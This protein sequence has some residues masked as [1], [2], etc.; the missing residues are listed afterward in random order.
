MVRL[1]AALNIWIYIVTAR[2]SL[3]PQLDRGSDIHAA[4][5]C[6]RSCSRR[7][8]PTHAERLASNGACLVVLSCRKS[9]RENPPLAETVSFE[10]NIRF[11]HSQVRVEERLLLMSVCTNCG[12]AKIVSTYDRTLRKWEESHR[13]RPA[14]NDPSPR[15]T[16]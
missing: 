9:R 14:V 15:P 4:T 8:V 16:A 13:C 5:I 11:T 6:N 2:A 7:L 10:P 1:Y 3:S 12:L